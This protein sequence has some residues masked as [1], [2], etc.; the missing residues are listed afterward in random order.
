MAQSIPVGVPSDGMVKVAF[1]TSIGDLDAPSIATDINAATSL[2]DFTCWLTTFGVDASE[3][4]REVF[5]FCSKQVFE[6][7]GTVTYTVS[8]LVYVYDPQNPTSETN[9]VYTA[10]KEGTR[11]FLV[12]GWGKDAEEEWAAGDVVD[13]YPVKVGAQRKQTPERNSELTVAQKP[14][15]TGAIAEDRALAA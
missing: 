14:Y 8:D 4:T 12:V 6:D 3:Q 10:L 15:V 2:E 13:I 1:V 9:K 5:R 11:G 7:Y